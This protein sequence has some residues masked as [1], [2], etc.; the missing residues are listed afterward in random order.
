MNQH[1]LILDFIRKYKTLTPYQA[2]ECLGITKLATRISELRAKG[3]KIKDVW[4]EN[5][6]RYGQKVR[7]KKYYI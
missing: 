5:Y 6:N 4:E 3:V 2:Y 7:Y 1:T